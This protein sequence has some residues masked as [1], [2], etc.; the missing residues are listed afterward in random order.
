MTDMSEARAWMILHGLTKA[1][2][3]YT[4]Y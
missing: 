3:A 4:L 1:D 2:A